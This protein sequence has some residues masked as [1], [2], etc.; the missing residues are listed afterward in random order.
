MFASL[1]AALFRTDTE[2][3]SFWPWTFWWVEP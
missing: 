2:P 3:G 1:W